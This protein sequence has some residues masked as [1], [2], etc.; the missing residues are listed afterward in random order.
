MKRTILNSKQLFAIVVVFAACRPAVAQDATSWWS[1]GY[2][3]WQ[4]VPIGAPGLGSQNGVAGPATYQ[5]GQVAVS[6]A[7]S[8]TN[9]YYPP[10]GQLPV[11]AN[12]L[13]PQTYQ[14]GQVAITGIQQG[15]M[16]RGGTTTVTNGSSGV[17]GSNGQGAESIASANAPG[18][19]GTGAGMVFS[20]GLGLTGN[21][22]GNLQS[23]P[24]RYSD[25]YGRPYTPISPRTY[26]QGPAYANRDYRY[27]NQ[28]HNYANRNY[29]SGTRYSN[30]G[31]APH[32]SNYR[33]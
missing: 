24:Q 17:A 10:Q 9:V 15:A 19:V 30:S 18:F 13:P 2:Q 14:P 21:Q 32:S 5:P 7:P 25:R 27:S 22:A 3:S 11:V 16:A 12:S 26:N 20:D 29:N 8:T 28:N 6:T 31:G 33:R 23:Y 4:S 1:P